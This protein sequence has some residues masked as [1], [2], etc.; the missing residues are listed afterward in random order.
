MRFVDDQLVD[1]TPSIGEVQD[2]DGA[3]CVSQRTLDCWIFRTLK[4]SEREPS[5]EAASR[6]DLCAHKEGTMV[7]TIVLMVA[8]T[9]HIPLAVSYS[10][11]ESAGTFM[12]EKDTEDASMHVPSSIQ[13]LSI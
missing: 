12:K 8:T 2:V 4:V 6:E 10:G 13:L 9:T 11:S 7:Y 5:M 1:Q 3:S